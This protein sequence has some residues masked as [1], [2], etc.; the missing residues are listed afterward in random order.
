MPRYPKHCARTTI[1]G[2]VAAY[3]PICR[4]IQ[5]CDIGSEKVGIGREPRWVCLCTDCGVRLLANPASWAA[6]ADR[7]E[8][9]VYKLLE[10]TDPEC[11][12]AVYERCF[13]DV[14]LT[15]GLASAVDRTAEIK[16]ALSIGCMFYEEHCRE[17]HLSGMRVLSIFAACIGML[18]GLVMSQGT[19]TDLTDSNRSMGKGI[20]IGCAVSLSVLFAWWGWR[21]E[22]VA[23]AYSRFLVAKCLR[24]LSP[25]V[26][27]LSACVRAIALVEPRVLKFAQPD[28]LR[29]E[30]SKL[31]DRS[32]SNVTPDVVRAHA[33]KVHESRR[34]AAEEVH[35]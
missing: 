7:S 1:H 31:T 15:S 28:R 14:Q 8:T 33:Q 34:A 35:V 4:D 27:E 10:Q 24:P 19:A 17:D 6:L 5:S 32:W 26:E 18:V 2:R 29:A 3:C 22:S 16:M 9:N 21:R 12:Y 20:M 13:A 23:A 11:L 25:T 30:M